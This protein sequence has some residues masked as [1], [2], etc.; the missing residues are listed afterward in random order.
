[1][2]SQKKLRELFWFI[3][4]FDGTFIYVHEIPTVYR[5]IV[6]LT[7]FIHN[8]YCRKLYSEFKRLIGLMFGHHFGFSVYLRYLKSDVSKLE[9]IIYTVVHKKNLTGVSYSQINNCSAISSSAS[10]FQCYD[11]SIYRFKNVYRISP[12][13]DLLS[14]PYHIL[15]RIMKNLTDV[16][17]INCM[18]TCK[19]LFYIGTNF[20]KPTFKDL[21]S[22]ITKTTDSSSGICL[23]YA[24][25]ST[26]F[27]ETSTANQP[28][29]K[30]KCFCPLC[31]TACSCEYSL[32][33]HTGEIKKLIFR[34]CKIGLLQL[35]SALEFEFIKRNLKYLPDAI[36]IRFPIQPY[37]LNQL[38]TMF[39]SYK[40]LEYIFDFSLYNKYCYRF[41]LPVVQYLTLTVI[42]PE[43]ATAIGICNFKSLLQAHLEAVQEDTQKLIKLSVSNGYI[44][45][46]DIFGLV[47]PQSKY[48]WFKYINEIRITKVQIK[49]K[50][51]KNLNYFT[52]LS[53]LIIQNVNMN[54][55]CHPTHL[56]PCFRTDLL[57]FTCLGTNRYLLNRK[58][59]VIKCNIKNSRCLCGNIE[60]M[61][62]DKRIELLNGCFLMKKCTDCLKIVNCPA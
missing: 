2:G 41:Q 33:Q 3:R 6:V 27:P 55:E 32:L 48:V 56:K 37:G 58:L 17:F 31:L 46:T 28:K 42:S 12:V 25:F 15:T 43:Y 39:P 38:F 59:L 50:D 45:T 10:L 13:S 18:M 47:F 22:Y 5:L 16:Y 9:R 23:Q 1:M 26:L 44:M 7:N 51:F 61:T 19:Q 14:L 60:Y 49:C 57:N 62:N 29:T 52:N 21:N 35:D 24:F 54:K 34:E 8:P 36:I 11:S 53:L 4:T 40:K 20:C 30:K